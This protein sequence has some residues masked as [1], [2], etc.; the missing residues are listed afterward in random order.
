MSRIISILVLVFAAG[1]SVA[2]TGTV[3]FH[4]KIVSQLSRIDIAVSRFNQGI[5]MYD[6]DTILATY[7]NLLSETEAT[8]AETEKIS[9]AAGGEEY[10]KAALELFRFYL[11]TFEN[12]YYAAVAIMY[13]IPITDADIEE[14][15]RLFD[16]I[17]LK[18]SIFLNAFFNE[19]IEFCEAAGIEMQ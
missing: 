15:E 6:G 18:E 17:E 9:I 10:H 5:V 8:I 11:R 2:Q 7:K 3:E 14:M 4:N 13:R 19:Q 12:D 16:H 1:I